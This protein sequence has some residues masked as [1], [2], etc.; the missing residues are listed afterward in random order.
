MVLD[1]VPTAPFA[2]VPSP[3]PRS[4]SVLVPPPRSIAPTVAPASVP[5]LCTNTRVASVGTPA[6]RVL[7]ATT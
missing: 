3:V 4:T 2:A 7:L 1:S 5:A 6:A